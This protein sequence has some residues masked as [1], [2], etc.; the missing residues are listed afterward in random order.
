MIWDRGRWQP[1]DDPHKGL[2]KGHLSFELD[3]EKLHGA[4]ASGAHAPPAR[5][6]ARQLAADQAARR[7]GARAGRQGY[8][9]GEAAV[10]VVRPLA[11]TRSPRAQRKG[12]AKK[13][14]KTQSERSAA[15]GGDAAP[16]R[17]QC[18]RTAHH[19][20][21]ALP[22]FVAP[23][24]ATLADKPPDSGNWIHEIKFDG[25]RIQAR[26]DGGKVKLLTRRG[27]DWTKK[28]PTIAEADRQAAGASRADR[29][30][31]GGRKATT[32]FP[33]SR[34]CRRTSRTAATTAWCSTSST[35]CISTATICDR[36]RCT[37]AKRRWRGCW[38]RRQSAG[39]CA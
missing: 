27:L 33:A 8:S 7:G 31:I 17:R 14:P 36:C 9:R 12:A 28:F 35:S 5:R 26:L 21:R 11:W 10:G 37:R 3:G 15:A 32:A 18:A 1:E 39:R 6:E 13:P 34:C 30:R 29:R 20:A 2:A 4:L 38:R 24:L 16:P 23:C 22:A 25:Y 19:G